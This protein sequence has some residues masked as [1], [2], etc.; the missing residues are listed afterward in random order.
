[1]KKFYTFFFTLFG[2]ISLPA[3]IHIKGMVTSS[4]KNK[5]LKSVVVQV[6]NTDFH[7]TTDKDGSYEILLSAKGS[8]DITATR[9]LLEEEIRNPVLV[10]SL[11]GFASV[12]KEVKKSGQL[13]VVLPFLSVSDSNNAAQRQ[14]STSAI[15]HLGGHQILQPYIGSGLN[16]KIAGLQSYDQNTRSMWHQLRANNSIASSSQPLIVLDGIWLSDTDLID[17]TPEDIDQ[18]QVRKG[19]A[20]SAIYGS[21]GGNGV[22]ELTSKRGSDLTQGNS[23][24]SLKSEYGFSQAPNRYDLNSKTHREIISNTGAQPVLGNVQASNTFTQELPSLQDY[25]N[26]YFF[27]NGAFQSHYLAVENRSFNTNFLAS[28]HLME[29][30]GISTFS[31]GYNRASLRFHLDHQLNKKWTFCAAAAYTFSKEDQLPSGE[32]GLLANTLLLTPIFDLKVPNEEDNSLY[33]WDID[34]TG[35]G[36]INPRYRHANSNLEQNSNRLLGNWTA[37]YQIAKAWQLRYSALFNRSN[38]EQIQFVEKGFLSS[39]VPDIFSDLTTFGVDGSNGGAIARTSSLQQDFISQGEAVYKKKVLGLNVEGGVRFQYEERNSEFEQ[40][41]GE[42]LAVSTVRSL[43]NPQSNILISSFEQDAIT[44]SVSAFVQAHYKQ[45][46]SFEGVIRGERSSLFGTEA[47]TDYFYQT[48]FAYILS[49]DIKIKGIQFLKLRAAMGTAGIRPTFEQRFS[50][51]RLQNGNVQKNILEN[52]SLRP[53]LVE[54]LEIGGDLTFAR[55]F[56][57]GF[58]YIQT[59]A[60][61]QIL[62]MPLSGATAFEG[63]WQNAGSVN[64]TSYEADLNI[65]LSKLFR[66]SLSGFRWNLNT[67]FLKTNSKINELGVP[68]YQN[69]LYRIEEGQELGVFYGNVFVR[70]VEQLTQMENLNPLDYT[71]NELGYIVLQ[72][73]LG[74]ADEVPLKL[75]DANGNPFSQIIGDANPDF[76]MNFAN[77]IAFRGFE[78]YALLDWKKGGDIYNRSKQVLYGNLRH[79]EVSETDIAASF[80]ETLYDSGNFNNHFVED[81]SYLMLRELSLAYTINQPSF[82]DGLFERLQ[83]SLIGRN[84][85]TWTQY[86]GYHPDVAQLVDNQLIPIDNFSLPNRRILTAGIKIVF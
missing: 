52:S 2:V 60:E 81:G 10:F 67:R 34:N 55:A 4:D 36:I 14:T 40:Q 22:I 68:T 53:T 5:P 69:S 13:D 1:M 78:L 3:Q 86:T 37:K 45:K 11:D 33:D 72:D 79:A 76:R 47:S 6:K 20:S 39:V 54:E 48:G 30:V 23:R 24:V 65:D 64:S 71:K 70:N 16:G 46:Y 62:L 21:A 49:E 85:F 15:G 63:Q 82:F 29:D 38:Q 27:Q 17:I 56:D 66:V 25:Q 31:E 59:T 12:E 43:D 74:T 18:I 50:D 26:D 51:F 80:Y 75:M 41:Q 9:N 42:N 19:A 58:S 28:A 84:L 57:L 77:S 61:D 83:F 44:K 73:V 35:Y 7:I 8:Y 32:N